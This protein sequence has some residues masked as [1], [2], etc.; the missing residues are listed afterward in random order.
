MRWLKQRLKA[1]GLDPLPDDV[2]CYCQPV[3]GAFDEESYKYITYKPNATRT[4]IGLISSGQEPVYSTSLPTN[5]A[6]DH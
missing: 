1:N 5:V 4:D 6:S 3:K 2:N